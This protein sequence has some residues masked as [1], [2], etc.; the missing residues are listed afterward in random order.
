MALLRSHRYTGAVPERGMYL[1]YFV[2]VWRQG[3]KGAKLIFVRLGLIPA[4]T[5][6]SAQK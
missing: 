6:G 2:F 3:H 1:C 4:V 5:E